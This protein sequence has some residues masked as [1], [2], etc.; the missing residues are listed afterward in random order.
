MGDA[1]SQDPNAIDTS[2]ADQPIISQIGDEQRQ[3]DVLLVQA[4]AAEAGAVFN[5]TIAVA[6]QAKTAVGTGNGY[7]FTPEQVDNLL[8]SA[9]ALRDKFQGY[10]QKVQPFKVMDLAPAQDEAGSVMQAN[11]VKKSFANLQTR[12]ESQIA[13]LTSWTNAVTA[14][15][16]NYMEQEHLTETQWTRLAQGL[17]P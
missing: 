10:R 7:V 12:I 15:K 9:Q 6:E 2:A 11:A 16:Q 14:A 17:R 1:G 5:P 13:F 3:A 4:V 8:T